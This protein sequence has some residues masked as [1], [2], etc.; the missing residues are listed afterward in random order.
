MEVVL[1]VGFVVCAFFVLLNLG[2]ASLDKPVAE[3]TDEELAR[4]LPKY[5]RVMSAATASRDYQKLAE[6]VEDVK[7][8]KAEIVRREKLYQAVMASG[9]GL[10]HFHLSPDGPRLTANAVADAKGG[11]VEAQVLVGSSYINGAN[12]LERDPIAGAQF[13]LKAA[14]QEHPLASFI[15]AGL[16]FEGTGFAKDIQKAKLWAQKAYQLGVPDAMELLKELG[17]VSASA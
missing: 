7:K 15:V 13:L 9:A 5:Q 4:G 2:R 1:I 8:I 3:W 16:Y 17:N 10:P 6:T 11:D 14:E 12:G